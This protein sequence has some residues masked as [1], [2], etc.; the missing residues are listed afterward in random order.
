[1]FNSSN[2]QTSNVYQLDQNSFQMAQAQILQMQ[3][4]NFQN[5]GLIKPNQPITLQQLQQLQLNAFYNQIA[6]QSSN[7]IPFSNLSFLNQKNNNT[8][9][10]PKPNQ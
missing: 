7:Y 4:M 10:T 3:M 2:Y 8:K 9:P 6:F 5:M 1:M